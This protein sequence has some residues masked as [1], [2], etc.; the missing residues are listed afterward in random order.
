MGT[1]RRG[2][3]SGIHASAAVRAGRRLASVEANG[4]E[5]G[6][7]G[8]GGGGKER[9]EQLL[10]EGRERNLAAFYP[11]ETCAQTRSFSV[12]VHPDIA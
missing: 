2:N 3:E 12:S 11:P 7:V 8:R 9:N 5:S 1:G 6:L 10:D 4:A